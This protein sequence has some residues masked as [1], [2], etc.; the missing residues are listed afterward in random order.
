MVVLTVL[1]LLVALQL[2]WSIGQSARIGLRMAGVEF[3]FTSLHGHW[4]TTL[5]F[6][7]LNVSADALDMAADML[8]VRLHKRALMAGKLRAAEVTLEGA[9]L[10]LRPIPVKHPSAGE[11]EP[12]DVRLDRIMV[13]DG[14]LTLPDLEAVVSSIF[15]EGQFGPDLA[16]R[17]DTLRASLQWDPHVPPAI[18]AARGQLAGGTVQVDTLSITGQQ[19]TIAAQG[20]IRRGVGAALHLK[21]MPL[22]LRD[23]ARWLP[24]T[25][26]SLTL[27]TQLTGPDSAMQ[28]AVEGTFTD[29]G[30]VAAAVMLNPKL[31]QWE[32]DSLRVNNLNP[33]LMT[34][35]VP[36]RVFANL[37]GQLMGKS[38][39]NLSGV[40]E[41]MDV[42]G[43]LGMVPME[44]V[45]ARAEISEGEAVLDLQGQLA[46]AR[47]DMQGEFDLS[48]MRG[49]VAG[50][51][52]GFD[53]GQY[54]ANQWSALDG[55]FQVNL[56]EAPTAV[57]IL[58]EGRLGTRSITA[59][60]IQGQADSAAFEIEGHIDTDQGSIT[61]KTARIDSL[62][63]GQITLSSLD[64][65]GLANLEQSSRVN[66]QLNLSGRWP[67][68]SLILDL[69]ADTSWLN[70]LAVGAAHAHLFVQDSDLRATF[71]VHTDAGD[72]QGYGTMILSGPQ[73][74]W[75]FPQ[76][77][78]AGADVGAL[79][80][81][82]TSRLAGK[83]QFA[84]RGLNSVEGSASLNQSQIGEQVIDSAQVI[85]SISSGEADLSSDMYWPEGGLEMA[86][87]ADSL[88]DTPTVLLRRARFANINLGTILSEPSWQTSL[89]G[90]V[91]SANVRGEPKMAA[92]VHVHLD[93]SSVNSQV[94][95]TGTVELRADHTGVAG[96]MR[97]ELPAGYVIVDTL[98]QQSDGSFAARGHVRELDLQALAGIEAVVSGSLDLAG[99]G[100]HPD[101][102]VLDH[103]EL[104]VSDAIV[105]GIALQAGRARG[106]WRNGRVLLDTLALESSVAHI[107]AA[108]E[109]AFQNGRGE[110]LGLVGHLV[111]ARPLER[112][113]GPVSGGDTPEDTFHVHVESR[114][115]S[116]LFS[117]RF[118]L[119]PAT[120]GDLRVFN[121]LGAVHGHAVGRKASLNEAMLEL[122]RISVPALAARSAALE[123]HREDDRM[124][125][126][127][128]LNIDDMRLASI[129]GYAD[130]EQ[131]RLVLQDFTMHLDDDHWHLDQEAVISTGNQYRV[132][133]LLLVEN[134]QEVAIDGVVDFN[135]QQNLG[136]SLYNVQM[137]R[138][139]DLLG[140]ESLGGTVNGGLFLSG[141]A[142]SP[143]LNGSLDLDV[144]QEKQRI[145]ALQT[146]VGYEDFRL[147]MDADLTH[148]DGSSMHL[149]GHVPADF[150]LKKDAPMPDV[151]VA[152][153]MQANALNLEW[154]APFLD[155]Q[156][157][158]GLSGS[159]SADLDLVGT[160][161]SPRL[162]GTVDLMEMAMH[163]P[164]PGI[165]VAQ[166]QL[167]AR[168]EG[169]TV[170]VDTFSVHSGQG[171]LTGR[172][173]VVLEALR[174]VELDLAASLNEF[175][176]V[177]TRPYQA[178]ADGRLRLTGTLVRPEL[179]GRLDMTGAVIRPQE[180]PTG[181]SSSRVAFT[182]ADL[183]MLEQYF[184]IRVTQ[185]DTT[186]FS[187]ADAL[188][189]NLEMGIPGN[190]WLRSV[191]NPEMDIALAGSLRMTKAAF[192]EQQLIG[193]LNVVPQ[194]SSVHQFGRQFDIRNGRV[195]F[196]G[197]ALDPY[198]DLQAAMTVREQSAQ[199]AQ[200]TIL[201]EAK[202]QLQDP[203]S[204]ELNL[205]SEPISLDP[206]DILHYIATGRPAANAFQTAGTSTLQAGSNLAINQLN[207]LIAGAAGAGLGLDVVRIQPEGSRG[208]TVTAGKHISRRLFTSVSWP[209]ASESQSDASRLQSRKTL[210]VEYVLYP[211]LFARLR[212][213]TSA[214]GVSV[215]TQY[216][217]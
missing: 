173:Q 58:N 27:E 131:Q 146:E 16:I 127:G 215:L 200:V 20:H 112:W 184:N 132:R 89:T 7:G 69:T 186:T 26:E 108:G 40:L 94:V 119:G 41:F 47:I 145:G 148:R 142:G 101:S 86:V 29:G 42:Q 205:R 105:S 208:L 111:D 6:R 91:D 152:L 198:F 104:S 80:A 109:L 97:L 56:D 149:S 34:A 196:A 48:Q 98:L 78:F 85:L 182:E 59:G 39:D 190:V 1:A 68:D 8:T 153:S 75:S 100:S 95:R 206:A 102:L 181:I 147:S 168:S 87:T 207:A 35:M 156:A 76:V 174:S 22:E 50:I 211:W 36:G 65:A 161:D 189:M 135:G 139:A 183:Q 110:Q 54:L 51:F 151:D 106:A 210:S 24:P 191:H 113:L 4:L 136:I 62:L 144:R 130:L 74:S 214:L 43:S 117:A 17:L 217:W 213:D 202:G 185:Q 134:T 138:F 21:A 155:P 125:Y 178:D 44:A 9:D 143:V 192:E 212:A 194:L 116:L 140:F 73:P 163:L 33:A 63:T 204:F 83:L 128:A 3:S 124:R 53:I 176:L 175:R 157:V 77:I 203:N 57:L 46:S 2:P 162:V 103:V 122:S 209:L 18:L 133:N 120:L 159:L 72:V 10:R 25:D 70:G 5:E 31:S 32:I 81:P 201:L 158:T 187:L 88:F 169:A 180:A 67:V 12:P 126:H 197:P 55:S 28:L 150:R 172:G 188:S 38:I 60:H 82:M 118:G 141:P 93:S 137:E 164:E 64:I 52:S 84:G 107:R 179:T 171:Q 199:D 170:Q 37:S 92:G 14:S 160:A 96:R 90:A 123:I 193:T 30:Q 11:F 15:L 121:T 165:T 49:R 154:I 195:T 71:Q 114:A 66:A 45:H 129:R 79:G 166:G 216:T 167:Q 13:R 115:D 61:L 177:D 19:T 23:L 99:A